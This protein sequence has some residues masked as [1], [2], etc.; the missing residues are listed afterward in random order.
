MKAVIYQIVSQNG[1]SYIGSTRKTL[2]QRL[3][4]HKSTLLNNSH[5]SYLLQ[6]AYNEYKTF[7]VIILE[8]FE[9]ETN[10]DV[11]NKEQYY[12][13]LLKPE[14][15]VCKIAYSP[16]IVTGR[17]FSVE[18]INKMKLVYQNHSEETKIRMKTRSPESRAK[19]I[20]S[21]NGQYTSSPLHKQK[22]RE[23]VL[24]RCS[25]A[26]LCMNI[27]TKEILEFNSGQDAQR[28]LKVGNVSNVLL[29]KNKS[30][31]GYVFKFKNDNVT[32]FGDL[33]EKA[34]TRKKKIS[35]Y[36]FK[37]PRKKQISNK[38]IKIINII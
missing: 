30:I 4:V 20:I 2:E 19:M 27:I 36:K 15:N 34:I 13:D 12:I 9:Y 5:H 11:A 28:A 26:V 29:G 24:L 33:I 38:R 17:K 3:Y 1:D 8:E 16:I 35:G 7:E 14:Y 25:K 32:L 31:G 23:S 21:R 6:K 10:K 22:T 37:N 18:S